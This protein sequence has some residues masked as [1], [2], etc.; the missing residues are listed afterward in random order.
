MASWP[1]ILVGVTEPFVKGSVVDPAVYTKCLD[2][3]VLAFRLI[4][5]EKFFKICRTQHN[6]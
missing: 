5:E 2:G 3:H 1:G 6:S 4:E